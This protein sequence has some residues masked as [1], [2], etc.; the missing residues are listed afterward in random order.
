MSF[1]MGTVALSIPEFVLLKRVLKG[2]LLALFFGTVALGIMF[3]GFLFNA[4][5]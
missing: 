4:F 2:P 5:A 1:M 3:V